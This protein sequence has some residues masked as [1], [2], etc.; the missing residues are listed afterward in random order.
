MHLL[1]ENSRMSVTEMAK[2]LGVSR[3]T[4]KNKIEKAEKEL[5]IRYTIELDEEALGL[6]SPHIIL[7]KFLEKPDYE[8]IAKMLKASHVPQL[9]A[10]IDG[11]YDMLVYANA[12]NLNEYVYWDRTTRVLLSKYKVVWQPSDLAFRHLGFFP[13]RNELISRMKI[14]K[15]YKDML[16]LLN[17][18]SRMSFSEMSRK[19]RIRS[20]TLA[21]RFNKLLKE[22]YIKRFTM[23][24]RK[25]GKVSM[26]TLFGRYVIAD[27]FEEDSM[28]MRKE[29]TFLD[30]R[31][32]L[33]SR[34]LFSAQ[35]IGSYD[36][37]FV[38][39]YDDYEVGYAHLI[40]YYKERFKRHKAK[41][42]YGAISSVILGDFPA[43]SMDAR[44]D[45]KMMRWVPGA[46]SKVEEIIAP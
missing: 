44:K 31:I 46:G 11:S 12:E 14:P 1:S 18:N 10:R 20:N 34:C 33:I 21:Y 24:M 38:G 16:L 40:K 26:L 17:E 28:S 25:P 6:D 3:Q 45:F 13:L 23:V 27:R 8:G 43:R 5:G 2:E 37:F 7:I 39:A 15:D 19:L 29:I 36:F 35:L 41:A 30:D 32:P 42:M 9:S 4:V 22:G